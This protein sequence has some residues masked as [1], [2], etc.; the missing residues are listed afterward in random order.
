MSL[1]PAGLVSSSSENERAHRALVLRHDRPHRPYA[2]RAAHHRLQVPALREQPTGDPGI[3]GR[4]SAGERAAQQRPVGA[5]HT[6]HVTDRPRRGAHPAEP[7][8]RQTPDS[9]N[10]Q[11]T[12]I[13]ARKWCTS[14]SVVGRR[15]QLGHDPPR[16][17]RRGSGAGALISAAGFPRPP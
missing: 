9:A 12:V 3:R 11:L 15:P 6:P 2:A 13:S 16:P 10:S 5:V 4:V 7:P 8:L 14:A 1:V 17:V